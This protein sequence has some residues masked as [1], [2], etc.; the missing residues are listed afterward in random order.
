M[1]TATTGTTFALALRALPQNPQLHYWRG[2]A[3]R[4]AGRLDDAERELRAALRSA[5]SSVVHAPV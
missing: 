1:L 5:G 2:N 3:L 4:V